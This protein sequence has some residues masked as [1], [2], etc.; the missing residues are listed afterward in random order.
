MIRRYSD[1][2]L[3]AIGT[4]VSVTWKKETVTGRV[5]IAEPERIRIRDGAGFWEIP[6]REVSKIVASPDPRDRKKD[7]NKPGNR[8][9]QVTIVEI[10]D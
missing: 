2:D 6:M 1:K 4:W 7:L 8:S 3:P 5:M 10:D 9:E